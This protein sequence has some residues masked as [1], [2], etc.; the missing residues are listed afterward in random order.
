MCVKMPLPTMHLRALQGKRTC[1]CHQSLVAIASSDGAFYLRDPSDGPESKT[2]KSGKS[3]K[4]R[5][6]TCATLETP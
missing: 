5:W 6:E 3:Y 1:V 4:I 2:T